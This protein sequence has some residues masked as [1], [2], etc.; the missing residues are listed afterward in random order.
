M[1][2]AI[3]SI[4][5]VTILICANFFGI[6]FLSLD[7]TNNELL[8]ENSESDGSF[9]DSPINPE[10]NAGSENKVMHDNIDWNLLPQDKNPSAKLF[11]KENAVAIQFRVSQFDFIDTEDGEIVDIEDAAPL[12]EPGAPMVP[13]V[14]FFVAVPEG[15]KV[16][17]IDVVEGEPKE[18]EGYHL[19]APY[20]PKT[21]D[22]EDVGFE[23]DPEIYESSESFPSDLYEINGPDKIRHLEALEVAL[24]PLSFKPLL[25]SV[26]VYDILRIRVDLEL[27]N[28]VLPSISED[29]SIDQAF[30]DL[31]V[32]SYDV[33]IL[34]SPS[35]HGTRAPSTVYH[36]LGF[37]GDA[38]SIHTTKDNTT[39]N[40][41]GVPL[42]HD[43]DDTYY[44]AESGKTLYVDGFDIGSANSIATLEYAML[45]IQYKGPNGY[46]GDSKVRWAL[47]GSPLA[48]TT[49]QPEDLGNSESNDL[50]YD[51]LGHAGSP[52]TVSDLVDLDVKFSEN[53]VGPGSKDIPFDYIWLEFAYRE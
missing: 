4:I 50:T 29:D 22:G 43:D 8:D 16:S 46:S 44:D 28:Q 38:G 48:D 15:A 21:V 37:H 18:V 17:K 26:E 27:E 51:L 12:M 3:T 20:L 39:G 52:S 9:P 49:I 31:I 33:R 25:G 7:Q 6:I 45:H 5:A 40:A 19:I 41:G 47:E 36:T 13:E 35:S 42:L 34:N 23:P 53:G 30:L 14:R 1:R 24:Y 11:P 2:R 32:N 10:S